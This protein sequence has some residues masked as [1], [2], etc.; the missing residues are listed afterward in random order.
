MGW[1]MR[2]LFLCM[3]GDLVV[4]IFL[5]LK[6]KALMSDEQGG[7]GNSKSTDNITQAFYSLHMCCLFLKHARSL[8]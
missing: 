8:V 3:R 2:L 1:D 4:N 5:W 7:G 6:D